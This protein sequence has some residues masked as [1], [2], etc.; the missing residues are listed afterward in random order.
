M[1]R[2]LVI[3]AAVAAALL[4]QHCGGIDNAIDCN[5]ICARYQACFAK[6]Y[7]VGACATRCRTASA[8]D[9]DSRRKADVCN[10]CIDERSCASATFNCAIPC[11][12]I[13]P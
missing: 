3:T 1:I 12:S 4:S 2:I 5:A 6:D 7:D 8:K 13:V 10:A 9:T 11:T